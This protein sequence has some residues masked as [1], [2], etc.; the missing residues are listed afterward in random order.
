[1]SDEHANDQA[2]RDVAALRDAVVEAMDRII[3]RTEPAPERPARSILTG[4]AGLDEALGGWL[5]GGQLVVLA[6]RPA[7]GTTAL[8]LGLCEHLTCEQGR[9]ALFVDLVTK[10]STVAHR[11]LG[12]RADINWSKFELKKELSQVELA[13]LGRSYNELHKAPLFVADPPVATVAEID[14][15]AQWAYH[16]R[17]PDLI[18]IDDLDAIEPAARRQSGRERA[19]RAYRGLKELAGLLS[20]PIVLLSRLRWE[21]PGRNRPDLRD[22]RQRE[23]TCREADVILMLH[24]PDYYDPAD[25]PGVAELIIAQNN[26]GPTGVVRLD[27]DKHVVRFADQKPD[28][29]FDPASGPDFDPDAIPF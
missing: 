29:D 25:Q 22:L 13:K 3:A 8:G 12:M 6:G 16:L 2:A 15:L 14:R 19:A 10:R 21:E 20:V 23:T 11:L 4:F 5:P 28:P 18:V 9:A 24:R 26:L 7:M 27:Y 1:M 17:E